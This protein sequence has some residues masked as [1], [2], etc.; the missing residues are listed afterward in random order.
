MERASD[1]KAVPFQKGEVMLCDD[2]LDS[3][4]NLWFREGAEAFGVSP[5]EEV[6]VHAWIVDVEVVLE[7]CDG[8]GQVIKRCALGRFTR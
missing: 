4:G 5:G 1:P 2:F 6:V 8:I 3:C 7:A